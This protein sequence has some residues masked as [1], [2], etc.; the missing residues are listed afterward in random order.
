MSVSF[1]YQIKSELN[2]IKSSYHMDTE[3]YFE[4]TDTKLTI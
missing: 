3:N 4:L 2:E 1:L